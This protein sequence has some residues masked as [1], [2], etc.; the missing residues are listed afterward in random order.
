MAEQFSIETYV[1]IYDNDHGTYYEIGPDADSLG[2][3]TLRYC[4]PGVDPLSFPT[5]TF[6]PASIPRIVEGLLR[7]AEL[8]GE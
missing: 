1:R 7:V 2:M 5:F 8:N 3:I 4:E 6:L